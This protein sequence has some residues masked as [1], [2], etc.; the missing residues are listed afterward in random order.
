MAGVIYFKQRVAR[1]EDRGVTRTNDIL[2]LLSHGK[3]LTNL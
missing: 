1:D 3:L 2:E